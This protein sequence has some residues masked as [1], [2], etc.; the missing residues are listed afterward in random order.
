MRVD[1]SAFGS[2]IIPDRAFGLLVQIVGS[3]GIDS[4]ALKGIDPGTL[5]TRKSL[6]SFRPYFFT[7]AVDGRGRD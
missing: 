4:E 2:K 3:K 6:D 1:V 7:F 5:H